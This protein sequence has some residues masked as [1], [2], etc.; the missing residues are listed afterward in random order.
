VATDP[1]DHAS[2]T[3]RRTVFGEIDHSVSRS[4]KSSAHNRNDDGAA[5]T[6]EFRPV[7]MPASHLLIEDEGP[8]ID[9]ISAMLGSEQDFPEFKADIN[10]M[11]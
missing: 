7:G 3:D 2:P 9:A 8:E 11:K 4:S 1:D 5:F 10:I 6:S